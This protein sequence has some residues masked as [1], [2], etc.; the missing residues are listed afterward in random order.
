MWLPLAWFVSVPALPAALVQEPATSAVGLE[1]GLQA[2][3]RVA[4]ALARAA[5]WL[6]A[7]QQPDG[8][9]SRNVEDTS[10]SLMAL[11]ASGQSPDR[12]AFKFATERALQW[13]QR[14]DLDSGEVRERAL[15]TLALAEAFEVAPS[16]G[17][18]ATLED[19]TR[20]WSGPWAELDAASL[21]RADAAWAILALRAVEDLDFAIDSRAI[22][23]NLDRL[24]LEG[25]EPTALELAARVACGQTRS[26]HARID[27][28]I[29]A[30]GRLRGRLE[31]ASDEVVL[32]GSVALRE[33]EGDRWEAWKEGLQGALLEVQGDDGSWSGDAD[34]SPERR[35]A[36]LMLALALD[37]TTP[38]ATSAPIR[39]ARPANGS[40]RG[41]Q[42]LADG[43]AWLARHQE[44]EGRWDC[45]G[46]MQRD[47][48]QD[49]CS[50]PGGRLHDV[51]VT[52]LALLAFL[53]DGNTMSE[54]PHRDVVT[55]G[56]DWL[57]GQ[58][59]PETGLIGEQIGHAFHYDHAIAS[60]AVCEATAFSR[61]PLL[62]GAA[63][64]A[65]DYIQ[66]ARNP[67]GA[68]RYDSPPIGDN[69][70]SVT[71][72]MVLALRAAEEAGLRVDREAFAGALAWLEEVTDPATGRIGYDAPGSRSSRI[73]GMNDHFPPEKG[74]AMT[75]AGLLC[76][77][78]LGQDPERT[79][80]LLKHAD[81]VSRTLPERDPAG[82]DM[83]YWYYGTYAMHQ[84]G[85]E[86]WERWREALKSAVL[87]S[88]RLDGAH[89]GSWDPTGPWGMLGGR[90]YSTALMALCLEAAHR[91]ARVLGPR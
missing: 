74:E 64:K 61:S 49:P 38:R 36:R 53:G 85:G 69:D 65:V 57:R 24:G 1:H 51:G 84:M 71:S 66:R 68:W 59:D 10:L 12:G 67:Y 50:G 2:E 7:E 75:A 82:N 21:D 6:S 56:V 91:Y 46:F 22:V 35:T 87:D 88:Q 19:L 63:Q 27:S 48:E 29:R 81:L 45:D 79:P 34:S 77:I 4:R 5:F 31:A 83:V 32:Y 17:L 13:L 16:E 80:I 72:W 90:V 15:A 89:K 3:P 44:P 54:G 40:R 14:T 58:Q 52:G 18:R 42:A 26:S 86:H 39:I 25:S 55:R 20:R 60:L 30:L 41:E 37:P 8:S 11:L 47:P 73:P 62:R 70:T 23:R 78:F 33:L 28:A 76:R 43:L 9:W